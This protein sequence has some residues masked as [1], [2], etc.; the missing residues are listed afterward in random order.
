[1]LTKSQTHG[2][3]EIFSEREYLE[4]LERCYEEPLTM[5]VTWLC[6][7]NLVLAIGLSF[8]TPRKG[9]H[10]AEV[11]N[12]LRA[13]YPH[14]SEVFYLNAQSLRNPLAGFEDAD[15]WSTQALCLMGLYMLTISKRNTAFAYIGRLISPPHNS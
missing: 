15:F 6:L 13:R 3:I 7:F 1:M 12:S 11:V 2:I 5:D 9:S 8:A 4:K 10:E 14:Q